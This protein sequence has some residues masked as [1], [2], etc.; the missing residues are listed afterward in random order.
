MLKLVLEEILSLTIHPPVQ[1]FW[2]LKPP[3]MASMLKT[4]SARYRLS[5]LNFLKDSK[6]IKKDRN[7][8][9]FSFIVLQPFLLSWF[10]VLR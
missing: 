1:A 4:S 2:K 3:V 9:P 5:N 6:C 10:H 8:R 7:H